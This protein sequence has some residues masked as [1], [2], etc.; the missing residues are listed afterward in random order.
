MPLNDPWKPVQDS[1]GRYLRCVRLLF[2]IGVLALLG[3]CLGMP[4]GVSPVQDFDA[5]RYLGRWYEIARLNHRFERGLVD[6]TAEYERRDD[7]AIRVINSG[8]DRDDGERKSVEGVARFVRSDRE[9]YLKVSFFGPFYGAYVV[10]VLDREGYEYAFVS[11][12]N[13]NYLWL[14]A[15]QPTVPDAVREHFVREAAARGF[16]T[17]ELIWVEQ[18]AGTAGRRPDQE[19]MSTS[20]Q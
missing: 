10:F 16:P 4:D 3:G 11:G 8:F 9:A 5:E 20:S 13:H 7:G 14:L 6:V 12:F 19:S 18:S 15:R 17:D 2:L 1:V